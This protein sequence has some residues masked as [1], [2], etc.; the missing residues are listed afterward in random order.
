MG[1]YDKNTKMKEREK[2]MQEKEYYFWLHSREGIG[3]VKRERLL[4]YF[5]TAK[6]VF[7]AKK[8]QLEEVKGITANDIISIRE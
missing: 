4:N 7:Q 1:L 3:S 5:G 8:E 6:E 2:K